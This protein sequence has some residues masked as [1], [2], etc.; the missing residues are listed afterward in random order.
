MASLQLPELLIVIAVV[1]VA[2]LPA[3]ATAWGLI[4]LYELKKQMKAGNQKLL[5][6]ERE[7]R[8]K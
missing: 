4:T 2:L 3:V 8:G 7:I 1:I 6:I 5:D